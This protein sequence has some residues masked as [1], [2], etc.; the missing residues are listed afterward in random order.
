MEGVYDR[1][2]SDRQRK[3]LARTHSPDPYLINKEV[4]VFKNWIHMLAVVVFIGL[5]FGFASDIPGDIKNK[6]YWWLSWDITICV[7]A[8]LFIVDCFINPVAQRDSSP[9]GPPES[10]K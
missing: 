9:Y 10:E 4:A 3:K 8:V 7:T 5:F 1:G 2:V 6:S